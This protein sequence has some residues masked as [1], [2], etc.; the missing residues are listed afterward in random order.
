MSCMALRASDALFVTCC[1]KDLP[2]VCR[3]TPR[4]EKELTF[5]SLSPLQ[6]MKSVSA[7][8]LLSKRPC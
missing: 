8:F 4:Y 7:C 1:L 6:Q 2:L 3:V 5:F